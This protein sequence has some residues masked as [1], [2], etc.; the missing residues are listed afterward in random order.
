M[1]PAR[2][3]V[4]RGDAS[5]AGTAF[6][7][8]GHFEVRRVERALVDEYAHVTGSIVERFDVID[9]DIAVRIAE[10]PEIVRGY[11]A[12]K[13]ASVERYHRGLAELLTELDCGS[14]LLSPDPVTHRSAATNRSAAE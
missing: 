8:F 4:A 11:E 3:A 2:L 13:L 6:D 9:T 5:A 10:L 7:P 14:D 1:V 12:I